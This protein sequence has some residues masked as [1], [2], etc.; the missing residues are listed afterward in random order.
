MPAVA[1]AAGVQRLPGVG[2]Q[3]AVGSPLIWST[4]HTPPPHSFVPTLSATSFGSNPFSKLESTLH[5]DPTRLAF[6]DC[7][8]AL[9]PSALSS[10]VGAC[11]QRKLTV[12]PVGGWA[13]VLNAMRCAGKAWQPARSSR[14]K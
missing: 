10:T 11:R 8:P 14:E 5:A 7:V 4:M 6:A 2:R 3:P 9:Q 1:S 12:T 13:L